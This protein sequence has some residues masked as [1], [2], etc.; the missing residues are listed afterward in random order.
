MLLDK[1]SYYFKVNVWFKL[2]LFNFKGYGIISC[3]MKIIFK[4]CRN[5]LKYLKKFV[6]FFLIYDKGK[7]LLWFM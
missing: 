6:K 2:V 3:D 4:I 5:F 7:M 1:Y